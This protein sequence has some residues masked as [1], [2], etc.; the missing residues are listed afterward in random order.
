[1][2]T[3]E[4]ADAGIRRIIRDTFAIDPMISMNGL[5]RSV[6]A[7]LKRPIDWRYLKKL[8]GKVTGE[9]AVVADR[10]KVEKRIQDLRESNRIIREE[11]LRI[12]FPSETMLERPGVTDRRKALEAIAR[13]EVAQV[14]LEMDLG[15]FT[16]HLGQI[17]VEHRLKPMDEDVRLNIIKAFAN[18]GIQAPPMRKIDLGRVEV[19][20]AAET[21]N[22]EPKQQPA[23]ESTPTKPAPAPIP[24]GLVVSQ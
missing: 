20:K 12:A 15:L 14:K 6:E 17:D 13:I 24:T 10:E 19:P 7:K 2:R 16:R 3:S 8:V 23:P 18:W 21:T 11:L 4:H 9:M 5:Q 22:A 1:M